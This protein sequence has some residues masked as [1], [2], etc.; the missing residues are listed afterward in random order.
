MSAVNRT[1]FSDWRVC[2]I[3]VTV[4]ATTVA[5]LLATALALLSNKSLPSDGQ[6]VRIALTPASDITVEDSDWGTP[7][8][9]GGG[10][11][12]QFPVSSAMDRMKL[13]CASGT[14]DCVLELFF[15][16]KLA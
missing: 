9:L 6:A 3:V 16:P 4:T 13:A 15:V 11:T 12:W 10:G 8:A 14:V 1:V 7:V 5:E 2:T